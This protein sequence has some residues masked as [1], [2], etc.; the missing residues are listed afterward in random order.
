MNVFIYVSEFQEEAPMDNKKHWKRGKETFTGSPTLI[1][2]HLAEKSR[3]EKSS[4]KEI[5]KGRSVACRHT[6]GSYLFPMIF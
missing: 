1:Y 4:E 5:Q 2:I 3:E 6:G